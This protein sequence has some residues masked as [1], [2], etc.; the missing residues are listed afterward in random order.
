MDREAWRVIIH[1]VAKE[2]D[3]T[4]QLAF[5]FHFHFQLEVRM[6]IRKEAWQGL[7]LFG[8]KG[9]HCCLMFTPLS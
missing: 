7:A 2:L 5:H 1:V 6:H 8:S 9:R 4:E 3:T